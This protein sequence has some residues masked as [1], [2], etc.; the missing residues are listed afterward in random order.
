MSKRVLLK[1]SGEAMAG[2]QGFGIDPKV[3]LEMAREIK[4]IVNEENQIAIVVGG[5]NIW[6]GQAAAGLG[7][8]RSQADYMGMMATVMNGLALQDSLESIGCSARVQSSL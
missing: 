4:S 5:G 2:T 8:D 1:L 3:V 6:R 7:M